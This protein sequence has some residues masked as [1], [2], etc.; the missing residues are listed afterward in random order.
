M[1]LQYRVLTVSLGASPS[2]SAWTYAPTK[3]LLVDRKRLELNQVVSGP[4][5]GLIP[6]GAIGRDMYIQWRLVEK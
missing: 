4:Y 5:Q 6:Q 3:K 2:C 1:K